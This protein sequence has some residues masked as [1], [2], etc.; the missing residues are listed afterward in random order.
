MP[1]FNMPPGVRAS[2]IPGNRPEDE[3][4]EA[5]WI[6][7]DE[8][9]EKEQPEYKRAIDSIVASHDLEAAFYEYVTMARE[10]GYN[11]GYREGVYDAGLE[12][13]QREED[14]QTS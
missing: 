4:E 1:D 14:G 9:F 10:L 7:L 12:A 5:F 2:D 11:A 6:E 13:S 3:A 8:K